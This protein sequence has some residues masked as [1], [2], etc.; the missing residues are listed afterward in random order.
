MIGFFHGQAVQ[1][2]L[3]GSKFI[4]VA[5]ECDNLS[6]EGAP[7]VHQEVRGQVLQHFEVGLNPVKGFPSEVGRRVNGLRTI[8][9]EGARVVGE[10]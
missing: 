1:S 4:G 3:G 6:F 5:K 10:N 7:G 2:V 9:G 8:I